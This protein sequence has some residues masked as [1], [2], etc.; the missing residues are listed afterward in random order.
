MLREAAL[1]TGFPEQQIVTI[2]DELES[3]RY[4]LSQAELND[5]VLIFADNITAVWK[6]IIYYGK[7]AP[8]DGALPEPHEVLT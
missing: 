6:E 4:A 7:Q 3:V 2:V 1:E 5:L 8:N